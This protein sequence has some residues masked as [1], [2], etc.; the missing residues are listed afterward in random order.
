MTADGGEVRVV[1]AYTR[2]GQGQARPGQPQRLDK[3]PEPAA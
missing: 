1:E 2:V 3:T